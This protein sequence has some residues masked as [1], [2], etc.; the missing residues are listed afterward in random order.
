M[1]AIVKAEEI[2]L[3]IFASEGGLDLEMGNA[4]IAE[5]Y[6]DRKHWRGE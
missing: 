4:Y 1:D 5:V 6:E 3:R 2:R